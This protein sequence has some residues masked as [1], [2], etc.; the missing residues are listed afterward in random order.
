MQRPSTASQA[1]KE[2]KNEM[3]PQGS[4]KRS[5]SSNSDQA[6][7]GSEQRLIRERDNSVVDN[8]YTAHPNPL[9]NQIPRHAND[10]SHN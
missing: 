5:S 4:G 8:Y 6:R 2:S 3:I 9:K 1:A 7:L 10:P